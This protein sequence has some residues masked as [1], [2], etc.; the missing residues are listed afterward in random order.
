MC[1]MTLLTMVN[2][3]KAINVAFSNVFFWNAVNSG[4]TSL[5]APTSEVNGKRQ[6]Q[7]FL[8]VVQIIGSNPV[9]LYHLVK[10]LS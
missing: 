1:K 7:F 9:I 3:A 6:K 2:L 8:M 10:A 5:R 4:T